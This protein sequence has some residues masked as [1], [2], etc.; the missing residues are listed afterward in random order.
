MMPFNSSSECDDHGLK[1]GWLVFISHSGQDV[2]IAKQIAREIAACGAVPFLDEAGIEI[3]ASFEDQL[4]TFLN[5]AQE[6]VVLITPWA[7]SRPYVWAE[8]GAAWGRRIPIVAVLYGITEFDIQSKAEIPGFLKKRN[9]IGLNEIDIYLNQ[10]KD[11][12]NRA[13]SQMK[14]ANHD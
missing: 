14:G 6:L 5:K 10:L 3:G 4:L 9:I 13:S 2:W 1:D 12:V 11:R 8:L 7:L